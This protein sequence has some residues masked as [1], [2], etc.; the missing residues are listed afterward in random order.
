[1]VVWE[2]QVELKQIK[3]TMK[4]TAEM[5]MVLNKFKFILIITEKVLQLL[6][7]GASEYKSQT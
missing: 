2:T 5:K 6:S 4:C 7:G 1:M 3:L